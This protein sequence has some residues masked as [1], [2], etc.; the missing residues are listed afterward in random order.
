MAGLLLASSSLF[1]PFCLML[2]STRSIPQMVLVASP[3]FIRRIHHQLQPH[4][5]NCV[6]AFRGPAACV[7]GAGYGMVMYGV[8]VPKLIEAV[9]DALERLLKRYSPTA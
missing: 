4:I 5:Q 9:L 2:E 8:L 3:R 1:Y 7:L 6:L